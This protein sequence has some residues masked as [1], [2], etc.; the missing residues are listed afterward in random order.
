MST[1]RFHDLSEDIIEYFNNL[2]KNMSLPIDLRYVYQADDKQK[3]LI[4][5]AKIAD[6]YSLLLK[7]ELLI[8]FNESYFDAFDDEARNILIEQELALLEFDLDK[9]SI[10]IGKPNFITSTGVLDKYGQDA[11]KRANLS[12]T[13]YQQQQADKE[14][15]EKQ[16]KPK[17]NKY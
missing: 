10:K 11:V 9:G 14:N 7:A 15:E 12:T 2:E 17:K 6:R 13:L 16:N 4:K 8:S 1:E 3:C 5:I